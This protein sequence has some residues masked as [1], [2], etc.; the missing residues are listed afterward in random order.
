MEFEPERFLDLPILLRKHV[1]WHLD[2]QL[3]FLKPPSNYQL[4]TETYP[5][6]EISGRS[7]RNKRLWAKIGR[8]IELFDYLR[9]FVDLWLEFMGVLKYDCIALDYMRMNRELQGSLSELEWIV[10]DGR[11]QLGLFSK[12]GVLQLWYSVEEY[13]AFVDLEF[14]PRTVIN[15]AHLRDQEVALIAEQLGKREL[16]D[17]VRKV[18]FYQE[19]EEDASGNALVLQLIGELEN[20]RGL[21]C[22]RVT[23]QLLF[24]RV[25]NFHGVRDHPGHTVGYLVKKRVSELEIERCDMIGVPQ[26]IA[27]FTRWECVSKVTISNVDTLDLKR[28]ML[29]QCCRRLRLQKVRLLEWW[30]Q[31][32][33]IIMLQKWTTHCGPQQKSYAQNYEANTE[34]LVVD[35]AVAN[36]DTLYRCKALMWEKYGNLSHI[37]LS[38]IHEVRGTPL[39]PQS[40]YYGMR[41]ECTASNIPRVIV[42]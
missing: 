17:L 13:S 11:T 22:V 29:P 21:E 23:G 32:E 2:G 15:S 14:E 24:E 39:V 28:T 10:I 8:F 34:V 7:K 3:T 1:Y 9:G 35:P 6:Y 40:W 25:V 36:K 12:A 19:D 4:F 16:T 38:G 33:T 5:E 27:D 18:S 30:D 31:E 20:L 37:Q 26:C 41:F 42:L